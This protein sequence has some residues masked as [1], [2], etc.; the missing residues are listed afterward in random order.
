MQ[1]L[2]IVEDEKMIRQGIN[3]MVRR[4]GIP[5][6]EIIECRN[7]L[8]ALDV[9]REKEVDVVLTDIRMPKMDGIKL[10]KEIS[11]M[12]TPPK[13]V[14]ISGYDDF[15]Y[16]VEILRSGARD[17]LLKPIERE[18]LVAILEKIEEEIVAERSKVQEL[19]EKE[20]LHLKHQ[21]KLFLCMPT[22]EN[23]EVLK[24]TDNNYFSER[25]YWFYCVNHQKCPLDQVQDSLFLPN[26]EGQD[27][28]IIF[29]EMA[30]E[31]LEG[32]LKGLYYGASCK[33]HGIEEIETAYQEA[34]RIRKLAF[35]KI[36]GKEAEEE[37]E[38]GDGQKEMTI[39]S[40]I[41]QLIGTNRLKEAIKLLELFECR[42]QRG[43]VSQRA[44]EEVMESLL[45]QVKETYN[46]VIT[47]ED[48]AYV[49]LRTIY[50]YENIE[51]YIKKVGGFLSDIHSKISQEFED[52]KNKQ[53]IQKAI[54][55]IQENY[56]KDLNMA[57][58]SN[59]ISMN[60]SL[61]S[62]VFKEFTGMN[63]VNY[64]KKLRVERAK[65]LLACT[66]KRIN[67]IS[68]LVGYE[69]EKHFMKVFKSIY[70]VSPSEYRKNIQVGN[71]CK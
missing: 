63:F 22:L 29:D 54:T 42:V 51:V 11:Y 62:L 66:D 65:E 46:N 64:V 59:Y 47:V 43:E 38:V 60:Y 8:E 16:A 68:L 56:S 25:V 27:F 5:I 61:F 44:F 40:R 6:E 4:S 31:Q 49:P 53:K 39:A 17:Y 69:N 57:V 9:L 15:S 14:V 18:K 36:K 26:M 30:K 58:V 50:Y 19:R 70:G 20:N 55:Y 33:H 3:S 7:G 37:G 34:I 1:R 71:V 48:S 41:T 32:I 12:E 2:V 52:Y 35:Y 28:Y 45:V 10:A 24:Q 21:L 13:V 23:L 67:E